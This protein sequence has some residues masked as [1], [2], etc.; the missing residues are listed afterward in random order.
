MSLR[1]PMK[2]SHLRQVSAASLDTLSASRPVDISHHEARG[3]QPSAPDERTF[4]ISST[5]LGRR[6]CTLW[7]HDETFSREEILFNQAA[8]ADTGVQDGDVI[9]ILPARAVADSSHSIKSDL[10]SRSLRDGHVESGQA[11]HSDANSKFKTPLQS[12]CLFVVKPLPQETK[13][14]HP[15]LEL[16]VTSNVANI[17][18]FKTRTTVSISIVERAQCS[19]SHVDISFR[20]QFLVRSD[21]WRLV[22]SEL[23]DKIIYKGQKIVFMGSIKATVKNIFIRG[24]KVLAGFFSPQ[25]IPV[26]RSEAAKYVLFIQM[27]R[28]MWDFDSEGTGDIL[29]SRVINGFLP[30]LFKRWANAE[31]RHLVTIVLFTRVEYDAAT[32]TGLSS[33]LNSENLKN[34]FSPNHVPTRDFYRVVVNDMASGQW[35]A[36]LDELKKDFRTFLRDVSILKMADDSGAPPTISEPPNPRPATIAGR[37]STALRGNILEAIHLASSHLAFDHID[38]DMIHTGTSIIV[39]TPGSGV[40]EVS[41]ESLASTAEALTNRGI[42]IDLVCLSPMP[43]HSVPLFKYREPARRQHSSPPYG[44]IQ[45]GG[46]SPEMRHSFASLASRTPHFSPKSAI[47]SPTPG[48]SPRESWERP[49][50]WSYGIPHWLDISYW[51]PETYREARRILKKDPNAPIPF[52]VTKKSKAF[53]PRVRMYEIQMGGVMESEQSNISIPYLAES[54]SAAKS[55]SAASVTPARSSLNRNSPFRHQLS[56]SLRPEPFLHSI[57]SAKDIMLPKSKKTSGATVSWMD[58]YDDMI[59]RPFPQRRQRRKPPKQKRSNEPDNQVSGTHDRL[60]ARSITHLREHENHSNSNEWRAIPRKIDSP[61]PVPKP[62]VSSKAVS[63]KK[64]AL[65]VAS[66]GKGPR[67]SRTI[68]FALR[69]LGV[70][71][72]RA[73]ASTEVNVAHATGLSSS[74]KKKVTGVLRE[75]RSIESLSTSDTASTATVID[76]SPTTSTPPRSL[77]SST[78]TPSRPI[79][80]KVPSKLPAEDSEQQDRSAIPES[81]STTGTEIPLN[82]G[83]GLESRPKKITPKFELTVNSASRESSAKT[84]QSKALAPWVRSI[85]PCNTPRDISRDTSWF[86]R[87]QHAYP[88]PPHVAVVKWKSLKSPAVLPLTTEEFPTASELASEYLQTPY[89]VF[90]NDDAEGIDVPKTRGVLLREMISLR[91]SHGFQIVVGKSVVEASGRYS[92]A[93]PNVFDTQTL[94]KDGTT[95]FLSKGHSIHRL[96]STGGTEIEVTQFVHRSLS[97]FSSERK[98]ASE[99]VYFP[100]MRTILSPAYNIKEIKL[101]S[102][103]EEYNWN[104]ADNYVA[105]HR[106]YLFNPAQQLHFWRVRYVLIPMRLHVNSRRHIQTYNEDN[107]EEIHLLG[108]NQLT[109]IWQRHKYVPPEEKR[110]ESSNK[111]R[112]QNPL[113]IVYQTRNPSEIVAAEL[114]RVLLTDPGLDSSPA[115]LLP[116]AELLERSSISL[117]SLAQIIQGDKGVRMMD[118]R[119]H[120][121]L[122][123]NCFIGFE[124]TTWL[125]RNFR[126]IDSREE[127]VEFG[128]EL[129]KHGLFQHVEKRH[130]FRDGNYFYQISSE[131]RVSR[132]ES[133]GSW[134]PQIRADK[135]VPSTP[136]TGEHWKDSPMSASHSRSASMEE[137]MPPTPNTPSKSKNKAA[138]ML[139]KTIRYDV[140]PRKRSNRPEVIDLHY[141]RLHNPGN[142]FHIELS[143]I[144]TSPKLI[145]DAV[146]SWASTAEKFGLKLVQVPIAEACAIDETQPFRHPYKVT[147]KVPPP[148]GPAPTIFT[149]ASF[150]QQDAPDPHYFQK[151]ILQ[152]YDFVLDFEARSAFPADV[153]VCYSW[154]RPDYQH[155]Q[156]IHQSGSLLSQITQE[157]DFLFLANRLVSTRPVFSS[158]DMP[159]H[160]RLD[161]P[162]QYRARAGTYDPIDRL[163]PRLSPLVRPIH[164]IMCSPSPQGHHSIDTT[165]LYRA[166]EHILHGIEEFCHDPVRLEQLYRESF[167]RPVSAK[168]GPTSVSFLDSSIPS[169]ELPAPVV[170]HVSPPPGLPSRPPTQSS[171]IPFID[172]R[173]RHRDESSVTKGSPRSG[174]L[175]PLNLSGA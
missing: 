30:E 27:S 87:W 97:E 63:P 47:S 49:H 29:F 144:N 136:A 22:M 99:S 135:S 171:I 164:D 168:A 74:N 128:N 67:I 138:I 43:L 72:P 68:S 80:I 54:Q 155:N 64:P 104:Y 119:W 83:V 65:K 73:Q 94:E 3:D 31:A 169:L 32:T 86:G 52:T 163:S 151:A 137:N 133:R 20:D 116:E 11:P 153:E 101:R 24:K 45:S 40:F 58:N 115:Q 124:L 34:T 122:H 175:R 18:G 25:T 121:R 15:K 28:E 129:M 84:P 66:S 7:V 110:F 152:K 134:F 95:V 102:A 154:G 166:P 156:Y 91:L 159:R 142:C 89:R 35:T 81:F 105:G 100:A 61:L 174:G 111:K 38:R 69:G 127:A 112:D 161:R 96:I 93:S 8:F 62:H 113:N 70:T 14:R 77:K 76:V 92:L 90:P 1:G 145:E 117:T 114:D 55:L 170:G 167:A 59:F 71:P 39:I 36:I 126:D 10:G 17:F 51:N 42:A 130:N 132:P 157:G 98:T 21:M 41:S 19:A 37:P 26:F 75:S 149:A 162:E 2:R 160:E 60:S 50:E 147:L 56:D 5:G 44:D 4:R 141:D 143:W 109:H 12:R 123:Y 107:E 48:M 57:T 78:I 6:S 148:K 125:L 33:T 165:N 108:I 150:T 46:Y 131:Y 88:R 13:T 140:D 9:E 120:W 173:S 82:E 85:N 103:A 53:V 139:S 106:D 158:R 16:S 23:A 79:S 172:S 146:L 118:R